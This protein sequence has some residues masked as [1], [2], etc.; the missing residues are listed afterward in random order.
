MNVTIGASLTGGSSVALS[1]AG[2]TPGRS[3][4]VAP[5]HTR[6]EPKTVEFYSSAP[7]TTAANP[8]VAR[9]GMK[10]SLA[11]R[12]SEEGCCTVQA[13]FVAFDIGFRWHLNQPE[14]LVDDAIEYLQGL[15][16]TAGFANAMKAGILPTT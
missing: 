13:G 2:V 7:V 4:Y 5:G 15:V 16:F 3:T 1:P 14:S 10:I 11:S 6:L 8:G 9:S 12:T